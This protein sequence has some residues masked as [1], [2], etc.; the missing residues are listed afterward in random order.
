ML[1]MEEHAR[2]P[3]GCN[4]PATRLACLGDS[5]DN[6]TSR[7]DEPSANSNHLGHTEGSQNGICVENS[8]F[9]NRLPHNVIEQ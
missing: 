3:P 6:Q 7:G 2:F 8:S 1:S 9:F 4:V 5:D